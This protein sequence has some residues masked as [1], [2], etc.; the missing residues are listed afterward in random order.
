MSR[1]MSGNKNPIWNSIKKHCLKCKKVIY[2]QP[3]VIRRGGGKYC[4]MACLH[5]N[6]HHLFSSGINNVEKVVKDFLDE[7]YRKKW[8]YVGNGKLWIGNKNPDFMNING[9]KKL[10]EVF[11]DYWH[12]G[13]NPTLRINHFKNYGFDTLVLWEKEIKAN[14]HIEKLVSFLS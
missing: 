8:R 5:K 9:Q 13:E 11:G 14:Q 7:K 4:S 12:Q 10:I 2:V 3:N 6:A 1:K